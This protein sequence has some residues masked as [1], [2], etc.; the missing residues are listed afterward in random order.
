M[1]KKEILK[2]EFVPEEA[3]SPDCHVDAADF[4]WVGQDSE[5][6]QSITRPSTSFWKDAFSRIRK[7]KVAITFLI[8]LGIMVV[9]AIIIP[10]VYPYKF[11]MTD[12][13]HK[14]VGM[15]FSG[16]GH[17]HLFG[18]DYL[19]RDMF[20]RIWRG[21]RISLFI[22]FAAVIINVIIGVI[23]GG[24]AG[25]FGG[26]VD[27]ILM[28]IAEIINGIPYLL[29]VILLMVIM[30]GGVFTIIVAYSL[31]G[32][33]GTARLVRGEVMR[34][35]EQEFV[36]SAKSMGASSARIIR[37]HLIPNILSI[38]IVN[39]TLA[40]PN[41]IFTEAFLSFLGLGVPLPEA[42]WG[43]LANDGIQYFQQYPIELIIPAIFISITMLS[44]NLLGD[45]LRDAFDPKLRR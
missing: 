24:I 39:L 4:E 29:I 7:D 37:K 13:L 12:D 32:W 16:D 9:L 10:A 15:F 5:K 19:G 45:K 6:M 8:I 31:V 21:A 17:F 40:I 23:Y 38:I 42:S 22:A 26:M 28:R 34:L 30:T 20:A 44:F 36:V 18:T 27:N 33:V 43:T 14:H 11:D 3:L 1:K 35:K 25:Y 2:Q 41:A